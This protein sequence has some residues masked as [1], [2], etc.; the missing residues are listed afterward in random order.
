M[1]I[2][3][4]QL[5]IARQKETIDFII[6]FINFIKNC[7]Y[8][9]LF[10]YIEGR[11]K[12]KS[13]PFMPEN[14][15]YS[16]EE[17]KKVVAYAEKN[18]IDVIPIISNFGHTE[19]FLQFPEMRYISELREGIKGR[20]SYF[21][22]TVCPSLKE[23]YDFFEEYF[24]EIVKIFPSEYFHVGNDEVWDI[25]FC[26]LCRERLKKGETQDDIFAKHLQKTYEIVVKKLKKKM[27]MWDDMFEFYAESLKKIPKDI[28]MCTWD[29]NYFVYKP[30]THF[31]H[32]ERQ[33]LF[34]KYDKLGFNYIFCT[35]EL[36]IPNI[37]SFTKYALNYSPLGGLITNWERSTRFQFECYP[38]IAFGGRLWNSK[39]I[40]NF[41]IDKEFENILKNLISEKVNYLEGLKTYYF[42]NN[43][44][45]NFSGKYIRGELEPIEE[46]YYR[47]IKL[48]YSNVK[49]IEIKN[50]IVEDVE[51]N[52]KENILNF[53]LRKLL[54]E[55][56]RAKKT[57]LI[58][59]KLS[60]LDEIKKEKIKRWN[61]Y[62]KGIPEKISQHYDKIKENIL[63]FIELK[64]K[65]DYFL[66]LKLFLPDIYGAPNI[67]I[68]LIDEKG[69]SEKIESELNLKPN[70]SY[71]PYY[72]F[73]F[74]FN[75]D[76]KIEAV[77]IN[78]SGYGGIGITY[79][80]I[81][82]KNENELIPEGI[83][84][85]EGYVEN[86][87]DLLIENL[88]WT[89]VGLREIKSYF[90]CNEFK[91]LTSIITIKMKMNNS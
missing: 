41:D 73:V 45:Y 75:F 3:G 17:I 14:E 46:E 40:E 39:N 79:I 43:R 89:Y 64:E 21:P 71:M 76:R 36:L 80:K 74:P 22:M 13:F 48:I 91:D 87:C 77:K 20:F 52:L 44:G 12:T 53:E 18:K 57:F 49:N 35:R 4:V 10:L 50:E 78:V 1:K 56:L 7:G 26:S 55:N 63:K 11:I 47:T 28:I 31:S 90:Q 34:K 83:L 16:P 38:V 24:S 81:I 15:S 23:T 29:Y 25:G 30:D 6:D 65:A 19:H 27:M 42:I 2:K 68:Y 66:I 67:S 72:S 54:Y 32:L 5:D 60:E 59:K 61:I 70:S 37:Y 33:D 58:E 88:R 69:N 82:D 86:P 62:R 84:K 85:T 9:T 51:I 8:N